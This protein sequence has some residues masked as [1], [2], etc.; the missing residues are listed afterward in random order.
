M[1]RGRLYCD[2]GAMSNPERDVRVF[3]AKLDDVLGQVGDCVGRLRA[4]ATGARMI[5]IGKLQSVTAARFGVSPDIPDSRL[6]VGISRNVRSGI[7]PLNALRHQPVGDTSGWYIWAGETLPD[8]ADFF[9]SLH[10]S[11]LNR[12]CPEILPYLGLPPGWRVL[13]APGYEDVW[14]DDAIL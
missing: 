13:L 10:I 7:L 2:E 11:H 3:E 6:K 9:L 8:D 4:E 5:P 1:Y 14:H 12:W